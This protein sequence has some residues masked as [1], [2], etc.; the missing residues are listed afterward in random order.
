MVLSVVLYTGLVC[1]AV[2]ILLFSSFV[3]SSA[4][5]STVC[6][7]PAVLHVILVSNHD[8][9]KFRSV[10]GLLSWYEEADT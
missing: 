7:G 5:T 9:T 1:I 10:R 8:T 3:R 6:N 2:C 4:A